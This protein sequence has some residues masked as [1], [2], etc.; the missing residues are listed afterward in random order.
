MTKARAPLSP[1]RALIRIADLIGWDG[2]ATV[3]NKSEATVR[4]Y[5][6][7]DTEREITLQAAM[8]L[9]LAFRRAGGDGSPL[10][11]AYASRLD[12]ELDGNLVEAEHILNASREAARES[13]EAIDAALHVGLGGGS[14]REAM[15]EVSEAIGAFQSIMTK[16]KRMKGA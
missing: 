8:R 4:S 7:P 11:E 5:S 15:R 2:C 16:L 13:G 10:F 12:I 9:D 1:Y 3:A 6:D 14:R